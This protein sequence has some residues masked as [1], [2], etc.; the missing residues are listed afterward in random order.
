MAQVATY[1]VIS[2]SMVSHQNSCW[3]TK[4]RLTV[5]V[6][7][8][9]PG[10]TQN[11]RGR[12]NGS[13]VFIRARRLEQMGKR[14]SDIMLEPGWLDRVKWNQLIKRAHLASRELSLLAVLRHTRFL[15]SVQ[16]R[17]GC[18]APPTSASTLPTPL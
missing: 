4:W 5:S 3:M 2:F 1:S 9:T 17:K 7:F 8:N 11:T 10:K 12:K 18:I 14:P 15:W 13:W 6:T 16:R